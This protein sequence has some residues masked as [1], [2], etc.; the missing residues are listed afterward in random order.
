ML[1]CNNS[2]DLLFVMDG[3]NL[4]IKRNFMKALIDKFYIGTN[5][6]RVGLLLTGGVRQVVR[7]FSASQSVDA[8]K[9]YI[10]RL[11][12]VGSSPGITS[13]L[14]RASEAIKDL[15]PDVKQVGFLSKQLIHSPS[16]CFSI[17]KSAQMALDLRHK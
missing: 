12:D 8:I 10:D 14:T 9:T 3:G 13:G 5:D 7:P 4:P 2:V 15:R 17:N 1:A 16:D 6:T 11:K